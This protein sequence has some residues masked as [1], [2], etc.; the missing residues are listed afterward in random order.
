M[1][2]SP[3]EDGYR[4]QDEPVRSRA[5]E[6][7]APVNRSMLQQPTIDMPA[8]TD[9]VTGEELAR[10]VNITLLDAAGRGNTDGSLAEFVQADG[11]SANYVQSFAQGVELYGAVAAPEADSS[12]SYSFDVPDGTTLE[13]FGDAYRLRAPNGDTHGVLDAPEAFDSDGQALPT[14][15]EWQDAVL[16]QSVDLTGSDIAYPAAVAA[17]WQYHLEF[18]I[19][20]SPSTIWTWMHGC[21]N[22]Y[23]PVDGAPHAWPKIGQDLPLTVGVA[24]I[25]NFHCTY[26]YES[27]WL[28]S[29]GFNFRFVSAAGHVDGLGSMIEFSVYND[30]NARLGVRGVIQRQM[31][32]PLQAAY[33]LGAGTKW[34]EFATNLSGSVRT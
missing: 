12:F 8:L 1:D 25:G 6:P 33:K 30:F 14:S 32:L 3:H 26:S 17:P 5:T 13:P 7:A 2:E 27:N 16:T 18:D 22:C 28:A 10:G 4:Q 23:F 9:E 31:S 15:Y 29:G 11:Q 21:F 20:N 19:S 24:G 34:R